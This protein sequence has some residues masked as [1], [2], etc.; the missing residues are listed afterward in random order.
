MS[1]EPLRLVLLA[2]RPEWAALLRARLAALDCACPLITAPSWE[3]ARAL[4]DDPYGGL[5]LTTPA[6]QP[7]PGCCPL[8]TILLLEEE[9]EQAPTDVY[10]WLVRE[11]VA[12]A[13][14]LLETHPAMPIDAVADLAGLGSPESL[15][16][17]F[18]LHRL[19][20][21]SRYRQAFSALAGEPA[22]LQPEAHAHPPDRRR[23]RTRSQRKNGPP[24]SAVRSPKTAASSRA[25][26]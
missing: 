22:A 16:R 18:R 9:P 10:D 12:I 6:C 8:P 24:T 13:K 7:A 20:A 1:V 25:E 17:H 2:E 4:F 21:P 23:V 15:R 14:E 3:A 26:G 5:L 19:P 11:R